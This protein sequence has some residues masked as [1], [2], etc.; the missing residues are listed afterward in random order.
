[1]LSARS[2]YKTFKLLKMGLL[3][4][5]LLLWFFVF[6]FRNFTLLVCHSEWPIDK[7]F[8]LMHSRYARNL[9]NSKIK[10][11]FEIAWTL[12]ETILFVHFY[13]LRKAPGQSQKH[14]CMN[15]FIMD[16]CLPLQISTFG[17]KNF[18]FGLESAILSIFQRGWYGTF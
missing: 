18:W 8:L 4:T 14:Y 10:R 15:I 6:W 17:P 2:G 13:P 3:E 11:I 7:P 9:Y 1:M 12:S 16:Y 5:A